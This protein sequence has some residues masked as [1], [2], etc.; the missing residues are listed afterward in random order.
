MPVCNNYCGYQ[1]GAWAG[2]LGDGRAHTIGHII[3]EN[4]KY[5]DKHHQN[6][7]EKGNIY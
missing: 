2:Q 1:F 7:K 5:I 6:N 3:H 4:S